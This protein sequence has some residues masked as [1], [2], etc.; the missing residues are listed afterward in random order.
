MAGDRP[1]FERLRVNEF[2]SRFWS[3]SSDVD[4]Q[5][6]GRVEGLSGGKFALTAV[7][8]RGFSRFR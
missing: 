4:I 1:V 5:T 6:S 3:A 2:D 7:C 8:C